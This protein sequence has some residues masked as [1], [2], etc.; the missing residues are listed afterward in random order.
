MRYGTARA[1]FRGFEPRR[2]HGLD[3]RFVF[4]HFACLPLWLNSVALSSLYRVRTS[5]QLTSHP[6]TPTRCEQGQRLIAMDDDFEDLLG[7]WDG[8]GQDSS[9]ESLTT[10]AAGLDFCERGE[11]LF[12]DSQI[13]PQSTYDYGSPA[14]L[15]VETHLSVVEMG[16]SGKGKRCNPRC[17][18]IIPGS[19]I[20][21]AGY[22]I[23]SNYSGT[24]PSTTPPVSPLG[25]IEA[26]FEQI[27]DDMLGH[28]GQISISLDVRPRIPPTRGGAVADATTL[29]RKTRRLGFPGKTAEEAWRFS[30]AS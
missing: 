13:L 18:N 30:K 3:G 10:A 16:P 11:E 17:T 6:A 4:V 9:Q 15:V 26:V 14:G 5:P 22:G 19:A 8:I 23:A 2:G 12:D 25:K 28:A 24:T 1:W 29:D 21:R 20:D 27:A 7:G